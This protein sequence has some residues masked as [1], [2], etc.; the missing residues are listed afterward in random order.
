MIPGGKAVHQRRLLLEPWRAA[1][2]SFKSHM[3]LE[4]TR[5]ERLITLSTSSLAKQ[6]TQTSCHG[7]EQITTRTFNMSW[8][9]VD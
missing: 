5:L 7:V 6:R 8:L 4:N 9:R 3:G 2:T 1:V